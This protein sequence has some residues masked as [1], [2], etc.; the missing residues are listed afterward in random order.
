[1]ACHEKPQ[2]PA[3][4]A[5][6]VCLWS[7]TSPRSSSRMGASCFGIEPPRG[8][9]G[10]VASFDAAC[11]LVAI[12]DPMGG[13]ATSGVPPHHGCSLAARVYVKPGVDPSRIASI[14]CAAITYGGPIG[15]PGGRSTHSI[16]RFRYSS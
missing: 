5:G 11:N 14:I 4:M 12:I 9:E 16:N 6:P 2:G 1:M 15:W 13:V 3:S 8:D 10:A 7:V